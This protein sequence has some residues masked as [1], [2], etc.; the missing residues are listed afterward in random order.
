MADGISRISGVSDCEDVRATVNCLTALGISITF[1]GDTAIVHGKSAAEYKPTGTLS[2]GE[3][4]S[5]LRFMIPIALVCGSTVM[6]SG[7]SGLM[8]RPMSVYEDICRDKGLNFI[9]DGNTITVRG[10]ISSGT[11]TVVGNISSQFISGLLFALPCLA[12]NSRIKLVPPVESRSYINMTISALKLFG[13][14]VTWED[15]YTLVIPGG[16][17]Y[18]ARNLSVEGDYSGAAFIDAL[19]LFGGEVEVD[20]LVENSLQGDKAYKRIF[21]KLDIGTP[22]VHIEDCPDLGPILFAVAAAKSGGIFEGTKRL[23]IKESDRVLAMAEELRKFGTHLSVYDDKVVVYP[24]KFHAPSSVLS[25]HNDHR[26][27][28]ALAILLTV[29]GGEI[30]GAEAVKKS[31]PSFF[32]H[33]RELGITVIEHND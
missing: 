20:G 19:S 25:G 18:S 26:I 29:V 24:A 33:L 9:Q 17:T 21:P 7:K 1:D 2:A 10:P 11:Y 8:S 32:R 31:Y 5:T 3:S 27:V 4:G 14:S 13:I 30:E 12:G 23:K 28:M 6:F 16:Q 15:D 22:T